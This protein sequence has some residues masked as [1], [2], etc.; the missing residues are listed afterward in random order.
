MKHIKLFKQFDEE[1]S[2]WDE[3]SPFDEKPSTELKPGDIIA[4]TWPSGKVTLGEID[5]DLRFI[6]LEDY[7]F[8]GGVIKGGRYGSA[9]I[10][11]KPNSYPRIGGNPIPYRLATEEEK[12]KIGL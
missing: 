12:A 1:E 11:G 3:E 2:W 5:H 7:A 8:E 10:N 4:R 9:V 6:S